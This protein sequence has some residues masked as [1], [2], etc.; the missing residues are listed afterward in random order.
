M[1]TN[2]P[3]PNDTG[4]PSDAFE[5]SDLAAGGHAYRFRSIRTAHFLLIARVGRLARSAAAT[6]SA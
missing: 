4:D 2:A 5:R 1:L 6:C 3:S